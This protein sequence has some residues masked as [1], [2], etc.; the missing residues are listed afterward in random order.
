METGLNSN[1]SGGILADEMGLG[2]TLEMIGLF[3]ANSPPTEKQPN[4][5]ESMAEATDTTNC[6]C[7]KSE[8]DGLLW[9]QCDSCHTWQHAKCVGYQ[10]VEFYS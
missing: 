3:V 8:D 4:M 5:K 9:V 2:K 6:I 1:L 10:E 7:G